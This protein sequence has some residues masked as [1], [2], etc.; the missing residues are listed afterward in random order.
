MEDTAI[1]ILTAGPILAGLF[2]AGVLVGIVIGSTAQ[3]RA[4]AGEAMRGDDLA[5]AFADAADRLVEERD[6][7]EHELTRLHE[8]LAA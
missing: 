8:E 1:T 3:A 6:T 2:G 5:L 7:A 4:D